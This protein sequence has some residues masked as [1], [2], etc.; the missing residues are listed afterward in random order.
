[1]GADRSEIAIVALI[2]AAAGLI[3]LAPLLGRVGA[4]GWADAAMALASMAGFAAF[5]VVAVQTFRAARRRGDTRQGGE[6]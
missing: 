6:P 1:M 5:V 4:P 3:L 2:M